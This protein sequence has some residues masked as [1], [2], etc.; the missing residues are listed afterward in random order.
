VFASK[1]EP[2]LFHDL[3]FCRVPHT[4]DPDL[5]RNFMVHPQQR[6]SLELELQAVKEELDH[7]KKKMERYTYLGRELCR[8]YNQA[9]SFT[10]V[11][12]LYDELDTLRNSTCNNCRKKVVSGPTSSSSAGHSSSSSTPLW[13]RMFGRQPQMNSGSSQTDRNAESSG[14]SPS[15]KRVTF[16]PT[17]VPPPAMQ[18]QTT[19]VD[20]IPNSP[21]AKPDEADWSVVHNHKVRQTLNV[22]L[23]H[24]FK[25]K[26]VVHCIKFSREGK[27]LAVGLENGETYIYDIK[28]LSYRFIPFCIVGLEAQL[29]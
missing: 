7:A 13:R 10:T 9:N 24:T 6:I 19:D 27:Y 3:L 8:S 1:N 28:T 14:V 16:E 21:D 23:A 18:R 26:S 29:T 20:N 2:C 4:T 15:T 25:M 11:T 22:Q 12:T 17:S 5:T